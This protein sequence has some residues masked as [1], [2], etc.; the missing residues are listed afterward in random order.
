M[1]GIQ[2]LLTS[3]HH[4]IST[5]LL[6][7]LIISKPCPSLHLLVFP[8]G[9]LA[10]TGTCQIHAKLIPFLRSLH[11]LNF[12]AWN[13]QHT[14]IWQAFSHSSG[15]SLYIISIQW[16]SLTITNNIATPLKNPYLVLFSSQHFH[17]LLKLYCAFILLKILFI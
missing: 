14:Q 7:Q 11:L 17:R 5:G 16:P 4:Q 2:S 12:S 8:T 1:S 10:V 9:L 6:Q 13:K 3:L 15:F